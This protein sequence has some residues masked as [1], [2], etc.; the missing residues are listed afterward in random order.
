MSSTSIERD[1]I[2][3]LLLRE[4]TITQEQ[5]DQALDEQAKSGTRLGYTLVSS[6]AVAE[7]DMLKL[8]SR[9]YRVPGVELS[10]IEV[11][12]KI[13]KL[14]PADFSNKHLVLPLRQ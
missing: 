1:H 2:G 7:A 10:E 11:D 12:P 3:E 9:L 6:G 4:K 5:L 13:L 8:L 14:V